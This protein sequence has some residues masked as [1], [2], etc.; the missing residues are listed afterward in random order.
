MRRKK[1]T[2]EAKKTTITKTLPL[3]TS[4]KYYKSTREMRRAFAKQLQMTEKWTTFEAS[5]YDITCN[6]TRRK[7]LVHC[8]PWIKLCQRCVFSTGLKSSFTTNSVKRNAHLKHSLHCG[9]FISFFTFLLVI[10]QCKKETETRYIRLRHKQRTYDIHSSRSVPINEAG[11]AGGPFNYNR[12][13]LNRE[14]QTK[15]LQAP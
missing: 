14:H 10:C 7:N 3:E 1:K 11:T 2:T 4:F 12:F 13:C 9:N 8:F 5:E 6:Y 15:E